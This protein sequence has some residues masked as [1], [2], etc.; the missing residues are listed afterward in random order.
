MT[1]STP[2][3]S[4]KVRV[5]FAKQKWRK[6]VVLMSTTVKTRRACQWTVSVMGSVIVVTT[7]MRGAAVS[8]KFTYSLMNYLKDFPQHIQLWIED[9]KLPCK[10][11]IR[12]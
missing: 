6:S 3:F 5:I 9:G 4:I 12:L 8:K 7:P 10:F 11:L 2:H 1:Y